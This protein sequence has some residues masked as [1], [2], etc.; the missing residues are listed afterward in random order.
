MSDSER[1]SRKELIAVRE[2][3]PDDRNFIFSTW[4]KG[5]RYGNDWFGL[6][7]SAAYYDNYQKVIERIVDAAETQMLIACL[8]DQPDV[9]LGYSVCRT[10]TAHYV[11]VKRSWRG[12]GIAKMLV[13][14]SITTVTHLTE[15]GRAVLKK[16][17][18]IKFNP[19]AI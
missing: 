9:I 7:E 10:D 16:Y 18:E 1:I 15:T 13:K 11:F 4:L 2:Y 17:P 8:A 14:P 5:L 19:F 3:V 12:I 6:I